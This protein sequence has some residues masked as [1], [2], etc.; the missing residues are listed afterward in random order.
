MWQTSTQLE[1]GWQTR[2]LCSDSIAVNLTTDGLL[3]SNECRSS[4]SDPPVQ[5]S[6]ETL[7]KWNNE[8]ALFS[9]GAIEDFGNVNVNAHVKIEE[10]YIPVGEGENT[11]TV[12]LTPQKD[13]EDPGSPWNLHKIGGIGGDPHFKRWGQARDSFHGECDLVM[14]HSDNFHNKAGFDLHVRTTI[15]TYYS[16]VESGAFRVGNDIV[17]MERT[18]FVVNGVQKTKDDLPYTFGSDEFRY[19]I[20]LE[21]D[22]GR[23]N[24]YRVDLSEESSLLFKFFK[25]YLTI[26]TGGSAKDF[27]D[28]VGI[29]GEFHTG[30]M[31]SRHGKR[32]YNFQDFCFEWQVNINANDAQLFSIAREPQ[33]PYEKCRLPSLPRPSRRR[34]LRGDNVLYEE[35]RRACAAQFGTDFDLCVDDVVITGEIGIAETW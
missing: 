15:D 9:S 11:F 20:R 23:V 14:L 10:K 4:A 22:D 1:N 6:Q 29:M 3:E 26:S 2:R 24:V 35:A 18:H 5:L 31:Y 13:P 32:M 7:E 16:Y 27:G 19:T 33:L 17:E 21:K 30:D 25:H 28:S 34:L 8:P 12:R